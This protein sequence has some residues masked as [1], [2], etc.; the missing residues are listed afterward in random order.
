MPNITTTELNDGIATIVAANALGYLKANTV[1]TRL[2]DRRWENEVAQRGQTVRIP[3]TGALTANDKAANTVVTLQNPADT[4]VNVT[5]N[6]HKEISF[7][8][9]DM[10][11]ALATPDYLTAYMEDA[12]KVMAEEID[13]DLLALYSG[14][15][16]T[17]DASAGLLEIHFREAARLLDAAKVPGRGR[18]AVLH[19]DAVY[20]LRGVAEFINTDFSR[21]HSDMPEDS[22]L[23]Y[24][25][26]G[27]FMGF[28]VYMD[29]MVNTVVGPPALAKNLFGHRQAIALVTRPLASVGNGYGVVQR[30]MNEDGI[31]LRVTLSYNPDHL[32]MQ[33]TVDVLYGVA[34]LRDNHAVVVDTALI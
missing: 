31:G 16:Q 23:G 15:S 5:L 2:V 25:Y 19:Q 22:A 33:C 26:Q 20:A 17:E 6:Q 13:S 28:S 4:G 7:L 30:T 21:L 10:A 8:I 12:M 24:A 3:F 18:Y 14:F 29:Q 34:E 1:M 11:A 9:E 27:S 32:G